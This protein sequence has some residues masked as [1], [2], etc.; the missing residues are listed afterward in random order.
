MDPIDAVLTSTSI[1][2]VWAVAAGIGDA[3]AQGWAAVASLVCAIG[4][5]LLWVRWALPDYLRTTRLDWLVPGGTLVLIAAAAVF[6]AV[7]AGAAG[8]GATVAAVLSAA[9]AG[10]WRIRETLVEL[11]RDLWSELRD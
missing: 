6:A 11:A 4:A 2:H 7:A 10:L 3:A 8:G 5:G 9:A 1:A